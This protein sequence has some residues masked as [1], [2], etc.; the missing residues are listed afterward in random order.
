M[1]FAAITDPDMR[2]RE[3]PYCTK[4]GRKWIGHVRKV[5]ILA[6]ALINCSYGRVVANRRRKEYHGV[7]GPSKQTPHPRNWGKHVRQT[8]LV[9]HEVAGELRLYL[10]VIVQ[11]RRDHFFDS[12]D[13][14]RIRPSD[15]SDWL[16]DRDTGYE[17]QQL[18]NPVIVK[19]FRLS[20]LAELTINRTRYTIA[21]A[22]TELQS[23][24]PDKASPAASQQQRRPRQSTKGR[25]AKGAT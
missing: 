11:Y 12:R 5:S 8:P 9:Q 4:D 6:G 7:G 24:L 1:S 16:N 23:Y 21:P 15:L 18:T 13:R 10:H 19:D 14:S 17:H 3:N 25:P 2:R 20:T 22:A